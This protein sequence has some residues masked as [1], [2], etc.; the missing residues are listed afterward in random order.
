MRKFILSFFISLAL[1][2]AILVS[3]LW[4]FSI[5]S[6]NDMGG[7]NAD[8]GEFAGIILVSNLPQDELK[9]MSFEQVRAQKSENEVQQ[10]ELESVL[11]PKKDEAIIKEN[12]PDPIIR[13]QK[14]VK[15]APKSAVSK[16]IDRQNIERIKSDISGEQNS[17]K[18]DDVASAPTIGTA[19]VSSTPIM[20]NGGANVKSYKGL[21][22]EHL[23]HYK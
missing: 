15:I 2:G 4:K 18:K 16:K 6:N 1:H 3:I 7:L 22:M 8:I 13:L 19:S 10:E 5:V 11:E 23:N 17:A 14:A 12:E 9:Q 20:G 21:L